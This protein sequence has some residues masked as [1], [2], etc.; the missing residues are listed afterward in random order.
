[1]A[2]N[3]GPRWGS[4][5]TFALPAPTIPEKRAVLRITRVTDSELAH[6]L[7]LEGKLLEAW[8]P[9]VRKACAPAPGWSG[10]T[11]LDLS[12]VTFVDA[13]GLELLR[14]LLR[15]G[16]EIPARSGYVAELLHVE[17]P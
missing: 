11:R 17:P 1:L 12:A 16:V 13:A 3:A 6:V 15:Q 4:G 5:T 2:R 9:E 14:E 7:R 10:R 8:V